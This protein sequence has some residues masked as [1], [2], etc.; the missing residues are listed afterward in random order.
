M[1][2]AK[3]APFF[4]GFN[5]SAKKRAFNGI[6][7][8]I[9]LQSWYAV[10]WHWFLGLLSSWWHYVACHFEWDWDEATWLIFSHIKICTKM[11]IFLI[12]MC[13]PLKGVQRQ[14][15]SL[16]GCLNEAVVSQGYVSSREKCIWLFS[17][18]LG[19]VNPTW[20]PKWKPFLLTTCPLANSFAWLITGGGKCWNCIKYQFLRTHSVENTLSSD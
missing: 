12:K 13:M 19:N 2:S 16:D 4:W 7:F 9:C 3:P 14:S 20:L 6:T 8:Q 5:I 15:M 18:A 10:F 1:P 11:C 17:P